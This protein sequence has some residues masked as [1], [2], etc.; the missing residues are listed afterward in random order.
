MRTRGRTEPPPV[1]ISTCRSD[2]LEQPVDHVIRQLGVAAVVRTL[3]GAIHE[4]LGRLLLFSAQA[5]EA[6]GEEA[7]LRG[8]GREGAEGRTSDGSKRSSEV[9]AVV[10]S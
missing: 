2:Q 1:S 9:V 10:A 5:G 4:R 8:G 7:V 3:P 6:V